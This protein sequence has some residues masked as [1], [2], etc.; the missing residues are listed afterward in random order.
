MV[1][2]LD[3]MNIGRAIAIV[4]NIESDK[5]NDDEKT[6]AIYEV[7]NM[8]THNSITKSVLIKVI[9]WMWHK[10]REIEKE[11]QSNDNI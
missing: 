3:K 11:G 4:T 6:F 10:F 1:H 9:K 5:F 7:M 8:P 2:Y